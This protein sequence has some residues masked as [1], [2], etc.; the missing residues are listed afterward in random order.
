MSAQ[1]TTKNISGSSFVPTF[2]SKLVTNSNVPIIVSE[3]P[4]NVSLSKKQEKAVMNSNRWTSSSSSSSSHEIRDD[5][6]SKAFA[7]MADKKSLSVTLAGT[8]ACNNVVPNAAGGYTVCTRSM[9]TYAHSLDELKVANCTFDDNCRMFYGKYDS[10][11][12]TIRNSQCKFLHTGESLQDWSNRTG[13]NMPNLPQHRAPAMPTRNTL[14]SSSQSTVNPAVHA[15]NVKQVRAHLK[16]TITPLVIDIVHESEEDEDDEEDIIQ[17][18]DADKEDEM[19]A[20]AC[21]DGMDRQVS[22]LSPIRQSS[23]DIAMDY[24]TDALNNYKPPTLPQPKLSQTHIIRVPNAELAEI[25][26]KAAFAVGQ[27]DIK[28]IIESE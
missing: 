8:K 11:G 6:R 18:L 20:L 7:K 9:C 13:S 1:A 25:A 28:I 5:P 14:L 15:N 26:L 4:L 3:L 23:D 12:L 21:M 24:I 17:N 16:Q 22:D 19:K 27:F 10:H 2:K